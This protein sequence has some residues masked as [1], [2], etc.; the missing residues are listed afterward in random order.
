MGASEEK[1]HPSSAS[2]AGDYDEPRMSWVIRFGLSLLLMAGPS[3]PVAADTSHA[4]P[5]AIPRGPGPRPERSAR[6]GTL[7]RVERAQAA[8]ADRGYS[9]FPMLAWALL[10]K[11]REE[12]APEEMITRALTLAPNTPSVHFEAAQAILNPLELV[13]ALLAFPANLPALLW[14]ITIL[15]AA[16]GVGVGV[17]AGAVVTV[18]FAR[19]LPLHGHRFGHLLHSQNPP[20]WPGVL[21]LLAA[22]ALLARLGLGPVLVLGAAGLLATIGTRLRQAASVAVALLVLGL[23]AGPLMKQWARLV[24]VSGHEHGLLAAWR[25]DRG[26][27]PLPNDRERLERQLAGHPEDPFLRLT[28]A[29]AWLREGEL[30]R[31]EKL[32]KGASQDAPPWLAARFSNLQG[33]VHLARGGVAAA[34]SAFERARSN[35][36]SAPILYNL[37]QAHGRALDLM[38]QSSYFK[39]ARELD[40]DL[41]QQRTLSASSSVHRLLIHTPIPLVG[42]LEHGLR[43]SPEARGVA[44]ESR[45]WLLGEQVPEWAWLALP[46]LALLGFVFRG[47]TIRACAS[48]G[49][50]VC[51]LCGAARSGEPSCSRCAQLQTSDPLSDSHR[52]LQ[53]ELKRRRRLAKV[54][55]GVSLLLP[56]VNRIRDG[57]VSRGALRAFLA[58]TGMALLF[59][60]DALPVNVSCAIPAPFEVGGLGVTLLVIAGLVLMAPLYTWGVVEWMRRRAAA[61]QPA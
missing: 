15:G 34:V 21:V 10:E 47:S 43:E 13:R 55:S 41:I 27:Q 40:P 7:E 19:A 54:L 42:Y 29:T 35:E 31:A 36:E 20:L 4:D 30:T 3:S 45:R 57:R 46:P 14:L 48:C 22:L 37:S 25:I 32:L 26:A 44:R 56:G 12:G 52:Q 50:P 8:L 11:A 1:K 5:L 24:T 39:R 53:R 33:I 38:K 23:L 2:E 28:M 61:R 49:R 17:A 9:E 58:T 59:L 60:A 51:P 6:L 16:A 18:A